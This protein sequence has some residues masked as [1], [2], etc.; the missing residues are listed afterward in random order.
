MSSKKEFMPAKNQKRLLRDVARMIKNPLTDNGIYYVHD[1]ENMLKGYALVFGPDDSLYRYGAYMFEFTY[2]SQYPFVPPKV[3]YLTNDGKT[4]FNPNLYRNGKV[5]ISLLNTWKGEQWTSCQTIKSILLSLVSLLHNEPLLN[6]PG[7]RKTHRDFKH[8]NSIIQY[9]NYE[10]AILGVLCG[11][12][13]PNN[14]VGFSPIIKKY[15][16]EKKE[17]ILSELDK[18]IDSSQDKQ[19]FKTGVYNMN[20]KTD[21]TNLKSKLKIAFDEYL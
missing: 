7:I 18:L 2:P 21:Y 15:L 17:T 5:C 3:T 13:L 8:Y 12:V 19:E 4:R 9:K 1:S 20:I 6:E 10:V 14:F 16:S 11:A